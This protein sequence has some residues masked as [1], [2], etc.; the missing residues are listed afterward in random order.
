MRLTT[1]EDARKKILE[2]AQGHGTETLFLHKANGRVLAAEIVA[3]LDS[4][5]FDNSEVDGFAVKASDIS[6]EPIQ[7]K[8][9]GSVF[10][11]QSELPYL[12]EGSAL[13]IF[14]GAPIPPGADS[15]VMQ[16]D[17]EWKDETVTIRRFEG[18]GSHIRK[19]GSEYLA[20]QLLLAK[21]MAITPPVIGLIA[22]NGVSDVLGVKLPKV[23][24]LSTGNEL[25]PIRKQLEPGQI[26][27][28]NGIALS[29]AVRALG[30]EMV[31]TGRLRDDEESVLD[32]LEKALEA[33]DVI[34]TSG[35]V[36]VGDH[37][38]IRPALKK[39]GVEELIWGI[40]V[41][42]GKPF[43]FGK[44]GKKLI[45][46]LP[47]NPVSGLVCFQLFVRPALLQMMGHDEGAFQPISATL[48]S[49]AQ[50][51]PSRTVFARANLDLKNGV[52][53][54]FPADAQESYMSSGLAGSNGLIA[55][56]CGA[57]EIASGSKVDV[58]PL[59][60]TP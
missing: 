15:V 45:F 58:Y 12:E 51:D 3:Q 56:P 43:Y 37:D 21:G 4:P 48:E 52:Y 36:S 31:V 1:F 26:Y 23:T 53:T 7:L 54:A 10:A 13:R 29:T 60:W 57:A 30:P 49:A 32:G 42:P 41:R 33:A 14:T 25:A 59:K 50:G 18:D 8:M 16:E 22:S 20:G 44:K 19:S 6:S 40:S 24:I 28:S 38:L 46:G 5:R 47:G 55:V 27:D 9:Q 17:C 39:L 11:G 34:I 35:G 2:H